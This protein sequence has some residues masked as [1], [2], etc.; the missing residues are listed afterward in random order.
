[1]ISTCVHVIYTLCYILQWCL[2]E[3]KQETGVKHGV[4]DLGFIHSFNGKC[5]MPHVDT[6]K[7]NRGWIVTHLM[8]GKDAT[9]CYMGDVPS[10]LVQ[11]IM[12]GMSKARF[13][14]VYDKY[15]GQLDSVA[16]LLQPKDELL[17]K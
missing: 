16:P 11:R 14:E 17:C 8:E 1:M 3:A 4:L 13:D 6:P 12:L 2:D 7:Y 5:Q 10:K 9:A 15:P